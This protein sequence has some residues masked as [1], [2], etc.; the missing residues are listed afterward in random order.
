MGP[1]T[2]THAGK[3][4]HPTACHRSH[5]GIVEGQLQHQLGKIAPL[6]PTFSPSLVCD[7]PQRPLVCDLRLQPSQ[8]VHSCYKC[9]LLSGTSY[10]L[11]L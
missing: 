4:T 8:R 6:G 5:G 10:A 3:Q 9:V 1:S 11:R 2:H 7:P